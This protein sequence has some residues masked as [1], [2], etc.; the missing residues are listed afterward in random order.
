MEGKMVDAVR[1]A[2]THEQLAEAARS[3]NAALKPYRG[4]MTAEQ[5]EMLAPR[6]A[7]TGCRQ[8]T[9]IEFVLYKVTSVQSFAIY[10]FGVYNRSVLAH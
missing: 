1:M 5:I 6:A 4:K 2:Q 7:R 8:P 10:F 9:S 3:L